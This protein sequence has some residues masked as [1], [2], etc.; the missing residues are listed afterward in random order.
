MTV[1]AENGV[2]KNDSDVDSAALTAVLVSE[3]AHG[4]LTFNADGSF[5]YTP[6]GWSVGADSFT[7][8]P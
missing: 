8:Q 4:S 1:S 6:A 7:L 2:L 5:V 3:P